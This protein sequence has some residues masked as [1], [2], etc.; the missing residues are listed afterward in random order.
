MD[1]CSMRPK[2]LHVL[3]PADK[4]IR[5]NRVGGVQ[6][7]VKIT[8]YMQDFF[9]VHASKDTQVNVMSL[10]EVEDLYDVTYIHEFYGAFTR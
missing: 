6:M 10:A 2:L 7:I 3:E 9:L 5:V 4:E 8:D 1:S